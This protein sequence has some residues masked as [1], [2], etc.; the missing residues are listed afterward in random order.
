MTAVLISAAI[1]AQLSRTIETAAASQTPHGSHLPTVVGNFFSY[2]TIQSNV[3]A[4]VALAVG[5]LW[6]WRRGNTPEPRWLTVLLAC[7]STYMI[8]TGL[9]YNLLLRGVVL[10]DGTTVPWS[11]EVLH[12]VGPLVMLADLLWS[13]GRRVLP[14]RAIGVVLVFPILWV[15]YTLARANLVTSPMSSAPWWYPYPFLDPHV[16]PSGY[17][18]V[19]GYITG[20]AV[21]ICAV[22]AF[23]VWVGRRES[24][25][26]DRVRHR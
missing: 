7:T 4:A 21:V 16:V 17:T 24:P 11:N 26:V 20:I 10:P 5:S 23:V 12:V 15:L 18:G 14:W 13:P 25:R 19:A 9:V 6:A 22:A 3:A 1:L 2:F 8:V